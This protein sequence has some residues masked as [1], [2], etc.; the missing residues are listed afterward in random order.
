[1]GRCREEDATGFSV[2]GKAEGDEEDAMTRGRAP[3]EET[4]EREKRTD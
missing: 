2:V 1:M 4:R 3:A